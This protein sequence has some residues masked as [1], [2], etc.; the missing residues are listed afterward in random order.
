MLETFLKNQ[1]SQSN[2]TEAHFHN[3][4]DVMPDTFEDS[5]T[6]IGFLYNCYSSL[7]ECTASYIN[8]ILAVT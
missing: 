2:E 5:L 7:I 6:E 1:F 4:D 8:Q 3:G